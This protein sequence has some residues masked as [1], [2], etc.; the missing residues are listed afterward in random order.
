MGFFLPVL[1]F[2]SRAVLAVSGYPGAGIS[3]FWG[4][5]V[6]RRWIA[7]GSQVGRM[8][9]GGRRWIAGFPQVNFPHLEVGEMR[10]RRKKGS[11][12][13]TTPA[14]LSGDQRLGGWGDFTRRA[15]KPRPI[16]FFD[17]RVLARANFDPTSVSSPNPYGSP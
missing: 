4:S 11:P 14:S 10:L 16:D 17:R 9:A 1:D 3:V 8:S 12:Q 2:F 13:K 15:V 5:Q 7:G 6:V